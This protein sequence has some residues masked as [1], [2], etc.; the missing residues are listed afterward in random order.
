M[1]KIVGIDYG[2]K[3]IGLAISDESGLFAERITPAKAKKNRTLVESILEELKDYDIDL[4]I[5]GTPIGLDAKP[6]KKSHEVDEFAEKLKKSTSIPVKLWNETLTSKQA[7]INLSTL[8]KKD[9]HSE[10]ARIML[11]EYLDFQTTGV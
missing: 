11:Q 3:N 2:T 8:S 6:T 9:Q 1:G 5:L 10:A 7:D 4:F